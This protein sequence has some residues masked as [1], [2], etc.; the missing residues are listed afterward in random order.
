M[1]NTASGVGGGMFVAGA[2]QFDVTGSTY[3]YNIAGTHGGGIYSDA[4]NLAILN[5]TLSENAAGQNGGGIAFTGGGTLDL[6]YV[7]IANNKCGTSMGIIHFGG[8]VFVTAGNISIINSILANNFTVATSEYNDFYG[9]GGM[10]EATYSA[11]G[12][13]VGYD[14]GAHSSNIVG[15]SETGIIEE[16]RLS[17]KLELNGGIT[18]TLYLATNSN[19]ASAGTEIAG[20]TTSQ[21]GVDR[22][23]VANPDSTGQ[24][25]PSM[26][27]YESRI[28]RYVYLGASYGEIID[29]SAWGFQDSAGDVN[30]TVKPAGF[31]IFDATF[32]F[33]GYA[34][35]ALS[36]SW[37]VSSRSNIEVSYSGDINSL[38]PSD[39]P[40]P[41][42]PPVPIPAGN[43]SLTIGANGR[44]VS[45]RIGE[46]VTINV[47]GSIIADDAS[48]L[49]LATDAPGDIVLGT[50]GDFTTVTYSFAGNQT[51]LPV[52]SYGNLEIIGSGVKS[53]GGD[54]MVMSSLYLDNV[55]LDIA[56]GLTVLGGGSVLDPANSSTIRLAGDLALSGFPDFSSVNLEFVGTDAAQNF[57]LDSDYDQSFASIT[58]DNAHGVD[59]MAEDDAATASD[60]TV[61]QFEFVN[62]AFAIHDSNLIVTNGQ[63]GADGLAG[64]YF[65]TAGAGT[66]DLPINAG[67]THFVL[68]VEDSLNSGFYKWTDV[69][70][71]PGTATHAAVR[72]MDGVSKDIDGK[73]LSDQGSLTVTWDVANADGNFIFALS[74]YSG[75]AAGNYFDQFLSQVYYNV[76]PSTSTWNVVNP[77]GSASN[78]GYFYV[79]HDFLLVTNNNDSGTGSLRLAIDT[80]NSSGAGVIAFDNASFAD[81]AN[82]ILSSSLMINDGIHI[83]IVGLTD[84]GK[85]TYVRGND[86]V[87]LQAG[88]DVAAGTNVN[89]SFLDF[90]GGGASTD[91]VVVNNADLQVTNV[92]IGADI[93][94]PVAATWQVAPILNNGSLTVRNGN[95][96]TGYIALDGGAVGN[97]FNYAYDIGAAVTLRYFS[98]P[99]GIIVNPINTGVEFS[100]SLYNLELTD[101]AIVNVITSQPMTIGNQLSVTLGSQ[102]N[103]L[104]DLTVTGDVVS[105]GGI[106][107]AAGRALTLYG[108]NNQ[109]GSFVAMTGSTVDY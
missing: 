38:N 63:S 24:D 13:F 105:T 12:A 101:N 93:M 42:N 62:G 84:P 89:L 82:V 37:S 25:A 88:T 74:A 31:D 43:G 51:I 100:S 81:D 61:G 64:K 60:I 108:A 106:E 11:V 92:S 109:L 99:A 91:Y 35:G 107:V 10:I 97:D 54:L 50:V 3:G 18:M 9:T 77:P 59:M 45:T 7:T 87:T 47:G 48:T 86:F 34:A 28:S 27:A 1:N 29:V 73:P 22:K 55:T 75:N 44:I 2:T 66:I 21:N 94:L 56:G 90:R 102:L 69:I 4:S 104:T 30:I 17:S 53:F 83:K 41:P 23:S 103:V 79:G 39:P 65:I 80:V 36:T 78:A 40:N 58:V 46:T 33:N 76:D 14:F 70:L 95:N 98:D 15:D 16:L 20:I 72:L 67:G 96:N 68:A 8:G 52:A 85:L 32:V 6:T 49:T 57:F 5:S 71:S 19:A 26:G